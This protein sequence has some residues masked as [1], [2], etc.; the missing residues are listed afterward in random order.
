MVRQ[1]FFNQY[2]VRPGFYARQIPPAGGDGC[3]IVVSPKGLRQMDCPTCGKA[4]L[5]ATDAFCSQCGALLRSGEPSSAPPV[6]IEVIPDRIP[7]ETASFSVAPLTIF[8]ATFAGIIFQPDLFFRK[9]TAYRSSATPAIIFA[10]ITGSI[11]IVG[12]LI[13][14]I[15]F[16][17]YGESFEFLEPLFESEMATPYALIFTP[18]LLWL[19]LILCAVYI[20]GVFRLSRLKQPA[21]SSVLRVTCYAEA[22]MLLQVLPIIG[23]IMSTILW[24]Y[25][26]ITGLS[27]LYGAG[28]IRVVLQLLLPVLGVSMLLASILVAGIL[29]GIAGAAGSLSPDIGSVLDL[30]RK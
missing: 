23:T 14:T 11:G 5:F 30:F 19:Q 3:R 8:R 9:I 18:V 2:P 25:A 12:S 20:K 27:H 7:W 6:V 21:F 13:W 15:L 17:Q 10:L 16:I 24:V 26:L 4:A 28:K 22:A 1:L 29:G